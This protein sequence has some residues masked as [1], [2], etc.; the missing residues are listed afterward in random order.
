MGLDTAVAGLRLRSISDLV[1]QLFL[2]I[3]PNWVI[4]ALTAGAAAYAAAPGVQVVARTVPVP[5]AGLILTA[6]LF[7]ALSNADVKYMWWA[8]WHDAPA[9]AAIDDA[10]AGIYATFGY[11]QLINLRPFFRKDRARRADALTWAAYGMTVF[12]LGAA[13]VI[14]LGTLR[15]WGM[16]HF[17]DPVA[18]VMR[19]IRV[20]EFFISRIGVA[21]LIV[22]TAVSFTYLTVRYWGQAITCSDLVGLSEDKVSYFVYPMAAASVLVAAYGLPILTAQEQ[23]MHHFLDPVGVC[24]E[25]GLPLLLLAVALVRGRPRRGQG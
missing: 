17:T 12:V 2:I 8:G 9:G 13:M 15:P 23:L 1:H 18:T 20:S 7:L 5:M 21:V 6:L 25:A 10:L 24:L 22:W 3:T 16:V 4:L 19:L 14:T 11:H